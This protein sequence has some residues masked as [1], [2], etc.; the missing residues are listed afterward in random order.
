MGLFDGTI[1]ERPVLCERCG[2]DVKQC[3]CPPLE[4]PDKTPGDQLLKIAL[5]KRKNGKQVTVVRGFDCR[6]SQIQNVLQSL[7]NSCGAGGTCDANTIEIQGNH[8]EKARTELK[9]LGYRFK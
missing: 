6:K 3:T 7:K 5:E 4:A 1:L 2:L 9:K 8:S